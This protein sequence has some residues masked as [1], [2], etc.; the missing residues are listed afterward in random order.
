MS[1]S[2]RERTNGAPPAKPV[3]PRTDA[4]PAFAQPAPD[5]YTNWL[6]RTQR[7]RARHSAITQN[8]YS[9]ANYKNWAERMR[10]SWEDEKK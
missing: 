3:V 9:W 7:A 10:T 4:A 8:L 2:N 6:D 1:S 5:T